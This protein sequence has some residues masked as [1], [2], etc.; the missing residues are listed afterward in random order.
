MTWKATIDEQEKLYLTQWPWVERYPGDG[1]KRRQDGNRVPG[2]Q[3]FP[4]E[5]EVGDQENF[6]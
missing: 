5:G 2:A 1:E 4:W 3:L 6:V